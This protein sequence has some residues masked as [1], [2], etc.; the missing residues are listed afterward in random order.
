MIGIQNN[1]SRRNFNCSKNPLLCIELLQAW[2]SWANRKLSRAR[3]AFWVEG[4]T[5]STEWRA[6]KPVKTSVSYELWICIERI[7]I[8]VKHLEARSG[9]NRMTIPALEDCIHA[10]HLHR[11]DDSCTGKLPSCSWVDTLDGKGIPSRATKAKVFQKMLERQ[12]PF[13]GNLMKGSKA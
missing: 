5:N 10:A 3:T 11:N 12:T 2:K 9:L 7:S 8:D 13:F 4:D 1:H 6:D